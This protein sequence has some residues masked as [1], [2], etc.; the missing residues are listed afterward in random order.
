[1]A[2]G[3][4]GALGRVVREVEVSI[5]EGEGRGCEVKGLLEEGVVVGQQLPVVSYGSKLSDAREIFVEG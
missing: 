4:V 2:E 1:V 3:E 5:T